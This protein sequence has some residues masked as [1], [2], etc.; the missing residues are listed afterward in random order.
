MNDIM[1]NKSNLNS[2]KIFYRA[3]IENRV[4]PKKLGRCQVR[5]L[6]IH[7][8]EATGD[9]VPKENL[10]WAELIGSNGYNG[11]MS[12]IGISAVPEQGSWVW[13]FLE[14]G[15]WNKPI[16][17]GTIYGISSMLSPGTN[18]GFHDP[19]VQFPYADRL[20]EPD[21]N[22]LARNEKVNETIIIT[23]K[24]ANR[25]KSI[26]TSTGK[27]WDELKETTTLAEYPNNRVIETRHHS[28]IELDDTDGNER[29]HYIHKTG[30]YREIVETGD[31]TNKVIRDKYLIVDRNLK[32]LIKGN[33]WTTV[34]GDNE[35]YVQGYREILVSDYQHEIVEKHLKEE[36]M[37]YKEEDVH[38]YL[39]EHYHSTKDETVDGMLTEKYNSTKTETVSGLVSESYNSGQTTDG[40]PFIQITAGVITLN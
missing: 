6:G 8:E 21:F 2:T 5:I 19:D 18:P 4:D 14:D 27:L 35:D 22:R 25:D 34:Y 13:V 12:G 39:K 31:E 3:V 38:K 1:Y 36:Y 30:T 17:V 7:S 23:I 28:Y 26:P 15:D 10:P 33:M 9:K 11:G 32:E 16:I 29:Y 40:G 24:D 20:N 37:D